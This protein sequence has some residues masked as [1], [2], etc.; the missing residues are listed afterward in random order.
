MADMFLVILYSIRIIVLLIFTW[1]LH[2]R[3]GTYPEPLL[4]SEN[5]K[6]EIRES[7]LLWAFMFIVSS[8]FGFIVN[9]TS[10][11]DTSDPYSPILLIIW[12]IVYTIPGFVIPLLFV[13]FVNQW[14]SRN[15]LGITSKIDQQRVWMYVILVQILLI[16]AEL[17]IRG[18][19]L[20]VPLFFLFISL[21]ATVFIEEF[22]YRGI[23]QSK[24]ERALGQNKG[25]FYGGIVFGLA[26]IP[27][28]FFAPIWGTGTVDI[29]TGLLMLGVQIVNGWWFGITYTKTRSLIPGI[30]IHYL[31]DFLLIY[32]AW[33]F[34]L[35]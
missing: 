8:I 10:I 12:A 19:P 35:V 22:L 33:F 2:K 5:P 3:I 31:A 29:V 26:H 16:F 18:T 11:I 30:I 23:I 24:L 4:K 7:L 28:N 17:S 13:L 32:I 34:I 21:Y 1:I 20:P 15:D 27:A 6:R 9:A 25:W 14:N